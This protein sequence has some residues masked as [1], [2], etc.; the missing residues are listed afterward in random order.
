M[1]QEKP[2]SLNTPLLCFLAGAIAG[3]VVVA[4][5]T[6]KKGADLREDISGL[7]RRARRRVADLAQRLKGACDTSG[8]G[9]CCAKPD[10]EAAWDDAKQSATRAGTELKQGMKD[11]AADLGS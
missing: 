10:A 5:T 3:A 7:G 9:C 1:N 8:E 11:V 2:S 4:L 6:P